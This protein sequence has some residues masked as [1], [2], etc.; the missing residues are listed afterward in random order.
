MGLSW[1]CQFEKAV[2][3]GIGGRHG[4][5]C[6][7]ANVGEVCQNIKQ[8]ENQEGRESVEQKERCHNMQHRKKRQLT[9]SEH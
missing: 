9:R 7:K 5:Q 2:R 3:M 6:S 4:P 1:G 8:G